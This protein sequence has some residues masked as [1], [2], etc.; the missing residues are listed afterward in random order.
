M[1]RQ[2]SIDAEIT[3]IQ[4]LNFLRL[5]LLI[6]PVI[7]L[8]LA[9]RRKNP[10]QK[11]GLRKKL[12]KRKRII[13]EDNSDSTDEDSPSFETDQNDPAIVLSSSDEEQ[14][15]TVKKPRI[16]ISDESD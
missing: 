14:K 4:G 7:A 10:R 9:L 5:S 16:V 6:F 12:R 15:T 8:K 13:C 3:E 1:L 11:I 2:K